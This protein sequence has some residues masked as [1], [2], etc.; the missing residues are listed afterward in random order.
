MFP[1]G[2][3]L[4]VEPAAGAGWWSLGCRWPRP[5]REPRVD[6]GRSAR[7]VAHQPGLP[8]DLLDARTDQ[9]TGGWTAAWFVHPLHR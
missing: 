2:P 4:P 8:A 6:S 1:V 9:P 7:D 5:G 3:L